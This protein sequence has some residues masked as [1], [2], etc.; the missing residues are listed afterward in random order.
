MILREKNLFGCAQAQQPFLGRRGLFCAL[1]RATRSKLG[2][3]EMSSLGLNSVDCLYDKQK[4]RSLIICI[5][6]HRRPF[7]TTFSQIYLRVLVSRVFL[8][9]CGYAAKAPVSSLHVLLLM[10]R[11]DLSFHLRY[12]SRQKAT[13]YIDDLNED[14]FVFHTQTYTTF[15]LKPFAKLRCR[16]SHAAGG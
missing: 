4:I 15:E 13:W 8:L 6:W 11:N 16:H 12:G 10:I 2:V 7:S 9:R 3:S 14:R 1:L 5:F